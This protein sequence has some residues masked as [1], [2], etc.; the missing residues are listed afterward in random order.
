MTLNGIV[1]TSN[2]I[3]L[4]IN[5]NINP[6]C[7]ITNTST[8]NNEINVSSQTTENFNLSITCDGKTYN[9]NNDSLLSN[10]NIE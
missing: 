4:S 7:N 5:P 1:Y 3:T 10:V 2:I 6:V 9:A 8:S